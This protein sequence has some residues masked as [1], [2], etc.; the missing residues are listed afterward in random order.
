MRRGDEW[1]VWVPPALGYGARA[2]GLIPAN[3]TL[4]FRTALHSVAPSTP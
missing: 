3:R 4:R 1:I 2:A